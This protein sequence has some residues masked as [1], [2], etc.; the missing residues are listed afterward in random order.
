[1]AKRLDPVLAI[2]FPGGFNWPIWVAQEKGFFADGG[3]EVALTPTPNSMFQ[4]ANL[5]EGQFD[6]AHTAHR[7]I[8]VAYEVARH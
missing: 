7:R 8:I 5:I 4:L 6:I 2:V 1:M 3:I